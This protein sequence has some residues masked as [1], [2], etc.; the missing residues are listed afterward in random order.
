MSAGQTKVLVDGV[1]SAVSK[2]G[3]SIMPT[4]STRRKQ[5]QVLISC[6]GGEQ[7]PFTGLWFVFVASDSFHSKQNCFTVL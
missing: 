1:G 6:A 5:I 4:T 2:A 7:D 3:L